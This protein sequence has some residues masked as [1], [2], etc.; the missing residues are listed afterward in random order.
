MKLPV[1]VLKPESR[2]EF[3][4]DEVAGLEKPTYQVRLVDSNQQVKESKC[5]R[6]KL[7]PVT[8]NQIMT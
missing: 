2:I 7:K 1:S 3:K 6:L 4:A 8:P 5:I